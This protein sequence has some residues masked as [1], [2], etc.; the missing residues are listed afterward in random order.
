MTDLEKNNFSKEDFSGSADDVN[1]P[2]N[3]NNHHRS[4]VASSQ[5][6][7]SSQ[8]LSWRTKIGYSF[9][10]ILNDLTG[11]IWFSYTLL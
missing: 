8:K 5:S 2:S 3:S 11:S 9:G 7:L 1:R 10:H 4:S 6:L